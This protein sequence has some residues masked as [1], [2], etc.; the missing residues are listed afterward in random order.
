[1]HYMREDLYK[2]RRTWR[3]HSIDFVSFVDCVH[4]SR[5]VHYLRTYLRPL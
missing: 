1:M 2:Q 3:V 5:W 4:I